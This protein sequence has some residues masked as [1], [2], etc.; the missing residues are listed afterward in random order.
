MEVFISSI[1]TQDTYDTLLGQALRALDG[2]GIE[3]FAFDLTNDA[4]EELT[5][6]HARY[7]D[8]PASFHSP[9][10]HAE[11]TCLPGSS[12]EKELYA[13]WERSIRLCRSFGAKQIVF[14][15]NNRAVPADKAE[16][17]R[18]SAM[19]HGIALNKMCK[20]NDILLLVE[21][22]AL[23]GTGCPIFTERQYIDY[24]VENDMSA[25]IDVGHMHINGYDY[26]RVVKAL[27]DRIK[28]YHI[29]NNDGVSDLHGR[30]HMGTFDYGRFFTLYRQYTPYADITFEYIDIPNLSVTDLVS[31]IEA[32]MR[33]V[34]GGSCESAKARMVQ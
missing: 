28:A 5:A 26:E 31:D 30:Y 14:H 2:V 10:R 32:F 1:L 11:P 34:H 20:E 4:E 8:R 3:Y 16:E 15:T 6:L 18:R 24:I 29:H 12:E 27:G 33:E 22:L 25:L 23:P 9:M 13:A 19:A 7:A 21:T 17:Y